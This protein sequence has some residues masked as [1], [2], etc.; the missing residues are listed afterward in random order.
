MARAAHSVNNMFTLLFL[1][2]NFTHIGIEGGNLVL[3]APVPDLCLPFT[4]VLIDVWCSSRYSM[5][6]FKIIRLLV[7]E[8]NVF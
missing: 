1:F 2:V 3:I 6:K 8:K 4:F 7:L 5:P